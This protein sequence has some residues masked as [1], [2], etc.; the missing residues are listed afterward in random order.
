MTRAA[1]GGSGRGRAALRLT[2]S[3]AAACLAGGCAL[4]PG[5]E[6]GRG[7]DGEAAQAQATPPAGPPV[8]HVEIDAPAALKA[9]LE[10]H[11]DL[12]RLAK[13]TRGDAVTDTE[14][15]R[16]VDTAPGQVRELLQ[17]EGYFTPTVQ[18]Q[19]QGAQVPGGPETVRLAI[20]PG[21]IARVQRI[22]LDTEGALERAAT[23]GDPRAR[24]VL[25]DW[26]NAWTLPSGSAFRNSAWSEAKT[27]ALTRLRTAGYA[28]AAWAGTAAEVDPATQEVRL[29]LVADSGPLFRAG[30]IQIEGLVRQDASTVEALAGF[31]PG[32]PVTE[33]LLLDYQERLQKSGLFEN[34]TVTLDPQ[35]AQADAAT[36]QVRLAEQP[37]QVYT[38]G[39]GVSANTGPRASVE[40]LYRRV[41][42]WPL[43][44]SNKIEWGTLHRAWT[45]ELSTHPK[46]GFTRWLLGGAI[47]RL[48]GDD[49][50]VLSQR[51]RF[52]RAQDSQRQERLYFAEIER[53]RRST[54][55]TDV[56]TYAL[57]ANAHFVWR[58]LDSVVL[59]TE[60]YTLALQGG[61]GRS[62]GTQ[63]TTGYFTRAYGRLTGYVPLGRA[64]YGQARIEF[65]QVYLPQGVA[66]PD[67]QLFRAGGDDSVRGYGYRTLG[68]LTNGVVG[69]GP[70]LFTSSVELARP[71]VD[72]MPSL[73][74][75][76]F[77][78]AG[79]AAADL[80]SLRPAIGIGAGVR[81][82]SPVGP[83][84][85]DLAY[86]EELRKFRLHFSVGIAF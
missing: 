63:S 60:G 84:R 36:V 17:T 68:P 53:G 27:V 74:G 43:S 25:R 29:F 31:V 1:W 20:A 62:H 30:R 8:V 14:L 24:D 50:V 86:G 70:V 85:L 81:W 10:R 58:R 45:G 83:L 11:L 57:S 35:V 76:V 49:D 7:A 61:V 42:G 48:V 72:S 56:S 12:S 66:A 2:A 54:P 40:H 59:P 6:R 13:M 51:L 32:A 67:S 52:G 5:T 38:V 79:R 47:D 71:F 15:T 55:A 34:V 80:Q 69:S 78:D 65:G 39:V 44:A 75:A 46:E 64:W 23:A 4:L 18:V 33:T 22:T 19:R 77:V 73:W 16:L 41:F 3:L 37:I 28:G 26:R 82:R 21:P 9:L